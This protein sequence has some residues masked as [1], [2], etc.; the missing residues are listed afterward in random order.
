[1]MLEPLT[2][3]PPRNAT[4]ASVAYRPKISV[5]EPVKLKTVNL[6]TRISTSRERFLCGAGLPRHREPMVPTPKGSTSRARVPSAHIWAG[7]ETAPTVDVAGGRMK[8]A[9]WR[10]SNTHFRPPN[11]ALG[12]CGSGG[13]SI[14]NTASSSPLGESHSD[15]RSP[16]C[17]VWAKYWGPGCVLAGSFIDKESGLAWGCGPSCP[18]RPFPNDL[19]GGFCESTGW[20]SVSGGG[21]SGVP[22]Q[23]SPRPQGPRC[24]RTG[25][26]C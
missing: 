11:F 13:F 25:G 14:G 7:F 6:Q 2:G 24:C 3:L 17:P 12:A 16:S 8:A 19:A 9:K 4:V 1:M 21:Q 10:Y 23:F 18:T 15:S 22:A 20:R 26:F 5:P